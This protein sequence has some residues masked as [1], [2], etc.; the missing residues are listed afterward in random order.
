MRRKQLLAVIMTVIAAVMPVINVYVDATTASEILTLHENMQNE[1]NID[2]TTALQNFVKMTDKI[3]DLHR[4]L[5][6]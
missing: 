1:T 5:I 4:R 2:K 3:R 6:L